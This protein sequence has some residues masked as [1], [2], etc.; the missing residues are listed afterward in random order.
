MDADENIQIMFN[1]SQI[2]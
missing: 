2:I 1:W